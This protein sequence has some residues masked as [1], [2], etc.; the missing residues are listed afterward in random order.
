MEDKIIEYFEGKMPRAE[1]VDFLRCVEADKELKK[2]FINTQNVYALTRMIPKKEDPYLGKAAYERFMQMTR[3]GIIRRIIVKSLAYAATAALLVLATWHYAGKPDTTDTPIRT[4]EVYTPAG[5]RTKLT[6]D[7]GSVVWLN[8][9]ST[10]AYHSD[11][12]LNR[13]VVLTGEAFFEVATNPDKPFT[14]A[15][16]G[17]NITALGTKF[18]VNAYPENDGT[19][20]ALIEGSVKVWNDDGQEIWL[21]P[22]QQAHYRSHQPTPQ[23]ELPHEEIIPIEEQRDSKLSL[24][25]IE[26]KDY[27]LWTSGIYSFDN[28]PLTHVFQK[29]ERYYDVKIQVADT[30]ILDNEFTGKFRQQDG[31]DMI[32]RIIQHIYPFKIQR[33]EETIVL[34]K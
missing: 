1:S 21:Q 15:T 23:H 13:H 24:Q 31:V 29:L 18:N 11:F 6:L 14:V 16:R 34:T 22:D 3:R 4:T 26:H 28:E 27:F 32:L 25:P 7:D 8:A 5:Q 17:V 30:S 19:Q 9:R 20:V 10:L 2:L 33:K 12:S